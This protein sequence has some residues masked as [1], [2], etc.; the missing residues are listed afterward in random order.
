M[1]FSTIVLMNLSS[2]K[3][4]TDASVNDS[5]EQEAVEEVEIPEDFL[6]FYHQFHEDSLFQK[7]HI[8]FP[9]AGKSE[10][11]KWTKENWVIHKSLAHSEAFKQSF[12]NL[13]GVVTETL[14]ENTGQYSVTRRFAKLGKDWNMIFYA[15]ETKLE[16]FVPEEEFENAKKVS[17]TPIKKIK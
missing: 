10:S 5:A 6:T 13:H 1:L 11:E 3:S 17:V 12:E 9:L 8:I 14:M 16:G 7:S 2:C 15:Q 4:N